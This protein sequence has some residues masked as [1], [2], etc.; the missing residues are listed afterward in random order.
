MFQV[1]VRFRVGSGEMQVSR[2]P[3]MLRCH[4]P[5]QKSDTWTVADIPEES[6]TLSPGTGCKLSTNASATAVVGG[7]N[8]AK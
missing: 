8:C 6:Q 2:S 7:D 4:L 1:L 3:V 5:N